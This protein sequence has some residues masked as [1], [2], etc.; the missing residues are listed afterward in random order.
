MVLEPALG[1]VRVERHAHNA[2]TDSP[3]DVGITPDRHDRRPVVLAPTAQNEPL[4]LDPLGKPSRV[5]LLLV[6]AIPAHR[7]SRPRSSPSSGAHTSRSRLASLAR[8]NRLRCI[9]P[10]C[11]CAA[12]GRSGAIRREVE[13]L[14]HAVSLHYMQYNFGRVHQSLTVT[15]DEDGSRTQRTPAMAAG[16]TDHVWTLTEIARLLD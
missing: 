4:G 8:W 2:G 14:A 12:T 13:K 6:P 3:P 1:I 15:N 16:V 9:R 5:P 10:V 7:I 11:A